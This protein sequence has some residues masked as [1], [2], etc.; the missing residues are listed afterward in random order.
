MLCRN[1]LQLKRTEWFGCFRNQPED[2]KLKNAMFPGSGL[3]S[4]AANSGVER[5]GN[6]G[7]VFLQREVIFLLSVG[8]RGF[9]LF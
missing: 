8:F 4:M 1:K 7:N 6:C 2:G 5:D 9:F 3:F